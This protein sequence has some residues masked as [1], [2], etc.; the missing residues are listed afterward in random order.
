MLVSQAKSLG[1]IKLPVPS[2]IQIQMMPIVF[3]DPHSIPTRLSKWK[4]T[5][6]ELMDLLEGDG[7]GY[8]TID[9]QKVKVGTSHRRP[10][11]HIDGHGSWGG[12]GGGSWAGNGMVTVS[13]EAACN[14]YLGEF[15]GNS[16]TDGDC[17]HLREQCKKP[18]LQKRNEIWWLD[19]K[20]LHES[21]PI[22]A[23]TVRQFVR[24]S[25]PSNA[26][27]HED[28]SKNPEGVELVNC[29]PKRNTCGPTI[30]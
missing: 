25:S 21:L 23:S 16:S 1:Q 5:I 15:E 22:N 4:K 9:E 29:L 26:R 3:H 2:G 6:C 19:G 20:C 24:I 8:L 10:G 27:P 12:G 30:Y 14:L 13:S 28:F 11:L 18:V 17:E 7:I